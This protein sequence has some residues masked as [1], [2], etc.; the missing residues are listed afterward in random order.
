MAQQRR[1]GPWSESCVNLPADKA[2]ALSL[3]IEGLLTEKPGTPANTQELATRVL[4]KHDAEPRTNVQNFVRRFVNDARQKRNVNGHTFA[5]PYSG[6]K[7]E[8]RFFLAGGGAKSGW[9]KTAIQSL[10][11]NDNQAFYG[12]KKLRLET[13]KR[14]ARF[15]GA[16][17][18]RFVIALGL[19]N[20][21]DELEEA[22]QL[23]PSKIKKKPPLPERQAARAI[24]KDDV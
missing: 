5:D 15:R 18:S 7:I 6:E 23:L 22:S 20:L 21:P 3:R 14:P 9:Y 24:T 8:L 13:V 11:P 19:T 16:E 10:D 17:F 4:K 2:S 1:H 12:V